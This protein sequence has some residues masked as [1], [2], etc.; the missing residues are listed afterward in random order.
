MKLRPLY[1]KIA[2]LIDDKQT[3]ESKTGL[4]YTKN[5]STSSNTT[6]VG[7]VVAVG[8]GRLM[9]DGKIV[10]LKVKI[11]DRVIYSKMQ[12]ESYNDGKNEYVLLA[13]Q[14][15]IAILEDEENANN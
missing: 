3:I 12:G 5:M 8:D 15:I 14:N 6:M 4:V 9:A 2:L 7:K 1:E 13:E 10:P 11:G